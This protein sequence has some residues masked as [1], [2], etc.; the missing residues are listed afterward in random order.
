[1]DENIR[2]PDE[3][4]REQLIPSSQ[5]TD[6]EVDDD[7]DYDTQLQR[8]LQLSLTEY[9]STTNRYDE[10]IIAMKKSCLE[11][12]KQELEDRLRLK[13]ENISALC[14][15]LAKIKNYD[16]K[17]SVIYDELAKFKENNDRF[18]RLSG[19]LW[20]IFNNFLNE[21]YY[22]PLENGLNPKLSRVNINY[23]NVNIK[24]QNV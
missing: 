6:Y 14:D 5:T 21:Y 16:I 17:A 9:K 12:E 4:V 15:L 11:K 7:E 24:Q 1:M 3:V 2:K 8:V 19:E 20:E 23:F 22:I 13:R 10:Q 18:L